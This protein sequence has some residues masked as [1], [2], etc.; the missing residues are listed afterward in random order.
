M[1]A[2]GMVRRIDNMGRV[3]IPKEIRRTMKIAEGTPLELFT[4][5]EYLVLGKYRATEDLMD[6]LKSFESAVVEECADLG[7]EK[8]ENIERYIDLIANELK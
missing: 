6:Q 1:K 8:I 4:N 2:T 7:A 5:G 3:V